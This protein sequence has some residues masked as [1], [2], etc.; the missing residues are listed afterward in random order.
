MRTTTM[1]GERLSQEDLARL[2]DAASDAAVARAREA[3]DVD[4]AAFEETQELVNIL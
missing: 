2:L 3:L 1:P 4:T